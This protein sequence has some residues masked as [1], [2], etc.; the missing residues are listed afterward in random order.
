MILLT[1]LIMNGRPMS[2][3][4]TKGRYRVA[5]ITFAPAFQCTWA[6]GPEWLGPLART[7]RGQAS[8][9][10]HVHG[11]FHT[12]AKLG[13]FGVCHLQ[14]PAQLLKQA[15]SSE[16]TGRASRVSRAWRRAPRAEQV[17]PEYFCGKIEG[18]GVILKGQIRSAV[19]TV[20]MSLSS[21]PK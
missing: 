10:D 13:G 15:R 2:K 21:S 12:E 7:N 11:D 17:T 6:E 14:H 5:L 8:V 18:D 9:I 1:P 19:T 16:S 3:R 20:P 4:P